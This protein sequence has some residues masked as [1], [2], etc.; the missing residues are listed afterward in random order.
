MLEESRHTID[1]I[2]SDTGF[3]D[4]RRMR[5]AFLRV[6]GQPPQAFRRHAR[7]ATNST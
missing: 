1:R 3:S 5:E 7:V 6:F 2:A 4:I